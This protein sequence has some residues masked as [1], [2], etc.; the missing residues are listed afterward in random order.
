MK[1]VY[2]FRTLISFNNKDWYDTSY[3]HHLTYCSEEDAKEG[4]EEV[5]EVSTFEDALKFIDII[6]NAE[7]GETWFTK[8]LM[9]EIFIRAPFDNIRMTKKNFKPFY[10]KF[11]HIEYKNF[12]FSFL[13]ENLP[14]DD[15]CE[16]L[17]D[18]GM[19][20]CIDK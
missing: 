9:I 3:R 13:S 12:S 15:F 16:W 8:K 10:V 18:R 11:E 19:T 20:I 2:D 6:P 5:F 14:G 1:K 4:K 7:V 17:K